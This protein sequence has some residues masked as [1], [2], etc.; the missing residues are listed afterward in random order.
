MG[1]ANK[2]DKRKGLE[3]A[4]NE[5]ETDPEVVLERAKSAMKRYGTHAVIAN[6]LHTRRHEA[7]II[8]NLG[9]VGGKDLQH[10]TLTSPQSAYQSSNPAIEIEEVLI[11]RISDLHSYFLEQRK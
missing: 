8:H 7:W 6:L 5:L 1:T 3:E 9:E 2:F 10:I 4:G 11:Q